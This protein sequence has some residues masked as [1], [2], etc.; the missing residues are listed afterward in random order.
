MA[1]HEKAA[2]SVNLLLTV[3]KISTSLSYNDKFVYLQKEISIMG[4]FIFLICLALLLSVTLVPG[5][6]NKRPRSSS[7]QPR[8]IMPMF[9]SIKLKKQRQKRCF[10]K[11]GSF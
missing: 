11:F 7:S 1:G 2:L 6:L 10:R 5:Q 8:K 9:N 3:V 4:F